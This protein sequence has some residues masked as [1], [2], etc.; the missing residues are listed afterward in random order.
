MDEIDRAIINTLQDGFPICAYPFAVVATQLGITE[1][2]LL[3]RLKTMQEKKIMT[4]FGP[5]FHAERLG[6]AIS[7]VAMRIAEKDFDTV[8]EQVNAHSEVAHNYQREHEFNM[9][10]VLATA[11]E[12]QLQD[13][14]Q[15]IER[16]T[17]YP[18]YNM[19]KL[20]EYY[21]KLRFIV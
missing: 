20:E 2:D 5:L 8:A 17:G 1:D 4:R 7:L 19:P 9:W 14:L 12:Q 15:S 16:K 11:T 21:L 18:V 10:F 6:G 13:A 3:Q